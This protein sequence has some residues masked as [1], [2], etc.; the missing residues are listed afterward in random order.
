MLAVAV[1]VGRELPRIL[2]EKIADRPEDVALDEHPVLPRIVAYGAGLVGPR[3]T[4]D[5]KTVEKD[6]APGRIHPP[7][8]EARSVHLARRA[9]L[10]A[11]RRPSGRP[12]RQPGDLEDDAVELVGPELSE[13]LRRRGDDVVEPVDAGL[14]EREVRPGDG[15]PRTPTVTVPE[16][17]PTGD[18]GAAGSRHPLMLVAPP[19]ILCAGH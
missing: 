7:P 14:E 9:G 3:E 15:R 6:P 10:S 2:A 5:R 17:G 8:L 12:G 18:A 16:S 13:V 11:C 4:L 1:A 19:R